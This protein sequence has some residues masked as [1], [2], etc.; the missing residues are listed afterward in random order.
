MSYCQGWRSSAEADAAA[1]AGDDR[2]GGFVVPPAPVPLM[3]QP[4]AR[5]EV[6]LKCFDHAETATQHPRLAQHSDDASYSDPT[7]I[8][9]MFNN[10]LQTVGLTRPRYEV[11]YS[12]FSDIILNMH[13]SNEWHK[14]S[15]NF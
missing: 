13:I 3:Q 10:I 8:D 7:R 5:H 9:A 14:T 2:Y 12:L 1:A 15:Q 6:K 11:K 4:R